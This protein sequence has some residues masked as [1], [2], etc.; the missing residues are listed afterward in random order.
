MYRSLYPGR[1]HYT[2]LRSRIRTHSHY[3]KKVKSQLKRPSNVKECNFLKVF[4]QF[5]CT[6]Q[7]KSLSLYSE[8]KTSEL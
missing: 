7:I 2:L 3:I 6:I 4:L 5:S 1:Q 8:I